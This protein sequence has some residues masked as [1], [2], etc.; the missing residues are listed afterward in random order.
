MTDLEALKKIEELRKKGW[1]FDLKADGNGWSCYAVG[2]MACGLPS[3]S[4]SL[5]QAVEEALAQA[6]RME[7]DPEVLIKA[8]GPSIEKQ[9]KE[10]FGKDA[11][12][13]FEVVHYDQEEPLK[14]AI[15]LKV[16]ADIVGYVDLEAKFY[17]W[18]LENIPGEMITALFFE[19]DWQ[20][21]PSEKKA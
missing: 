20:D 17:Q 14:I 1:L 12:A 18:A 5:G 10:L 7:D 13:G 8:H 9:V 21:E 15:K 11:F 3:I 19:L 4:S 16:K 2:R 6:S